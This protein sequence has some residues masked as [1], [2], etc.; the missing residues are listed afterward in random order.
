MDVPTY[1]L[2][3]KAVVDF[4]GHWPL[5]HDG[6]VLVYAAPTPENPSLGFTLH[7]WQSTDEID[8]KGFFVLQKHALV[9][10]RFDGIHDPEVGVFASG[11][12]VFGLEFFP[13]NDFS[14][15]RVVLDSVMDMSG[16]FLARKGEIVSVIP[17]TPD[18]HEV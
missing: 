2:N 18:G 6:E 11:N 16:S 13:S 1:I 10:F 14:S 5:F 15:F 4:Y 7:A 9:S 3:H 17:C 8:A 12:I